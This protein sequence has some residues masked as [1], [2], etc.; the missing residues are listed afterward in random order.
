M[1]RR[2][3]TQTHS[4][5]CLSFALPG[6][7]QPADRAVLEQQRAEVGR[8]RQLLDG[9][10]ARRPGRRRRGRREVRA[11]ARAHAHRLADVERPGRR[12]CARCRRR[13]CR[14][15]PVM[16]GSRRRAPRRQRAAVG[17]ARAPPPRRAARAEQRERVADGRGARA[18]PREQGAED[19]RAR[20]GV[21]ERAVRR[22]HARCR[23]TPASGT[24]W[25]CR[26]SGCS[27]RASA[28][29][30][31]V[32]G[33][34]PLQAGPLERLREDA[35]VERGAVRDEHAAAQQLARARAGSP[36]RAARR[37]PS[38]CVI[39]VNRWMPFESGRRVATSVS[40]RSC[41]SP[42]PTR[43]A[44]TSVSSHA[45]PA[46]PFV[47]VSTTRNSAVRSGVAG[48]IHHGL[49]AR[50]D[51]V[52]ATLRADCGNPPMG[53]VWCAAPEREARMSTIAPQD[54]VIVE[55]TRDA[56]QRYADELRDLSGAEYEAAE[57]DAWERLQEALA[58][59]HAEAALGPLSRPAS[60]RLRRTRLSLAPCAG[61]GSAARRRM[62]RTEEQ[63]RTHGARPSRSRSPA[64]SRPVRSAA[65]PRST[66]TALRPPAPILLGRVDH[67][68]ADRHLAEGRR[69]RADH[70]RLHEPHR[71]LA[72]GDVRVRRRTGLDEPPGHPSADGAR[73]TRTT[74]R[75]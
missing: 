7:P 28:T 25:R 40:Q 48:S 12:R 38:S 42:P 20:L 45:S 65:A 30:Q 44:P 59:A 33:S 55:R 17:R 66:R 49:R 51:G 37:R 9:L 52:H 71:R 34:R 11:H 57:R 16:S 68:G 64:R 73:S 31:I 50:P 6:R 74:P 14:C 23:A 69:R 10:R 39:P 70:A 36:R 41:S 54:P 13:A 27:R 5:T 26:A 61:V 53:G 35:A 15:T 43:T 32:G 24:S 2:Q 22:L 47:S 4:S 67:A 8:R 29:V 1:S 46:S 60:A 63:C 3:R 75:S 62:R 21:R 56:W 72:A 18:E 58:D 19:A